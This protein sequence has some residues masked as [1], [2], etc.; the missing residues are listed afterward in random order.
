MKTTS[1]GA[2]LDEAREYLMRELELAPGD[3]L[4]TS[5]HN[6]GTYLKVHMPRVLGYELDTERPIV[7]ILNLTWY[8]A[9]VVGRRLRQKDGAWYL[10]NTDI[11]LD[12]GVDVVMDLSR[13][14]FGDPYALKQ[15]WL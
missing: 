11:G 4:Y 14:L 6:G 10:H 12:R 9:P 3:T 13:E 5:H 8:V 1:G 2:P 7:G 15:R